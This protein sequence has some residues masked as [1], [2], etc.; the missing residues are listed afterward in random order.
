MTEFATTHFGIISFKEDEVL[1]FPTGLPGFWH[2]TRFVLLPHRNNTSI[3][4]LQS[5]DVPGLRFILV[6][7]FSVMP[8]YEL[9][10]DPI[11]MK[12]LLAPC[13]LTP[14]A[15]HPTSLDSWF[16]ISTPQPT[17]L[18][19][20]MLAPVVISNKSRRGVQAVRSDTRYSHAFPLDS[21]ALE[22]ARTS[23]C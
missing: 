12:S 8:E 22:L 18:T 17:L 7:A 13:I 9:A 10:I 5:A 23:I 14:D 2:A 1:T 15:L 3:R 21:L 20:N 16:I 11:D 19:I 4:Y 6:A